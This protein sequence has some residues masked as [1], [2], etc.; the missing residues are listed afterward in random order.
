MIG[1]LV[2]A[3]VARA[4]VPPA[5]GPECVQRYCACDGGVPHDCDFDCNALCSSS[6]SS[7]SSGNGS[8]NPANAPIVKAFVAVVTIATFAAMFA[9]A[10]GHT[11]SIVSR[12]QSGADARHDWDE[13]RRALASLV[14]EGRRLDRL[15]DDLRASVRGADVAPLGRPPARYVPIP[16]DTAVAR[17]GPRGY[18]TELDRTN[19]E[20][21]AAA[22]WEAT[23]E[24]LSVVPG[25]S[26]VTGAATGAAREGVARLAGPA[27][28]ADLR[29][30]R[31]KQY[32]EARSWQAFLSAML[33]CVEQKP[34]STANDCLNALLTTRIPAG[35]KA[36]VSRVVGKGTTDAADRVRAA[37]GFYRR[38]VDNLSREIREG[39]H[40]RGGVRRPTVTTARPIVVAL[41][42]A[43][44][45]QPWYRDPENRARRAHDDARADRELAE[46]R[47]ARAGGDPAR[48]AA[49]LRDLVERSPEAGAGT[50]ILLG[51][52]EADAGH[53]VLGRAYVR[54][55][56]RHLAGGPDALALRT[57]LIAS[58]VA[59]GRLAPALDLVEPPTLAEAMRFDALARP[60]RPLQHAVDLAGTDPEAA[61]GQ[62]RA[63]LDA[64]GT[65]DHPILAG[66]REAIASALWQAAAA[67][68]GWTP[69]AGLR[70]LGPEARE[71]LDWGHLGPALALYAEAAR[72]L[73]ATAFA[74]YRAEMERAAAAGD[75]SAL[76]PDAYAFAREGDALA[77]AGQLGAAIQRYRRAVARAPWWEQARR[78]LAALLAID[79]VVAGP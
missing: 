45:C 56:L 55:R 54:W 20:T 47:A 25:A 77:R 28:T 31:L 29:A 68:A 11:V 72:L 62:A 71:E 40:H 48:A 52:V 61:L 39:S 26:A 57:F 22:D 24:G 36:W 42:L 64:Y 8:A 1:A 41:L 44:A 16:T 30:R 69:L 59:E 17:W 43:A 34:D 53:A 76:A 46:A 12:R 66:A 7:S 58:F 6:S 23:Q 38:Y 75:V 9:V 60:L 74:P 15:D 78:N 13:D 35:A 32:D 21:L 18:C 33:A 63:W 79:R 10:P 67:R 49:L 51:E 19:T 37:A 2:G 14:A 65:P 27:A 4:D 5:S 3:P 73:P 70:R 50:W